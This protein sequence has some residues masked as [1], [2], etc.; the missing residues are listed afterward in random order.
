VRVER[1]HEGAC[2]CTASGLSV[3][4]FDARKLWEARVWVRFALGLPPGVLLLCR[5]CCEK[6]T[7]VIRDVAL[8]LLYD[9]CGYENVFSAAYASLHFLSR[10]WVVGHVLRPS[11]G[12]LESTFIFHS[13]D[14]MIPED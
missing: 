14:A 12:D 10:L 13:V 1:C 11:D 3:V 2:V 7:E 9:F 8:L 6:I 5:Q 4:A